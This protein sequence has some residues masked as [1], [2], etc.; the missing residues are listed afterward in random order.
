MTM[1]VE[2]TLCASTERFPDRAQTEADQHDRHDEL[3]RD[4]QPSRHFDAEQHQGE[5]GS[6][7]CECVAQSP[8]GAEE[9]SAIGIP[10][11]V[12]KCGNRGDVIRFEGVTQADERTD[13]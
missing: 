6:N 9:R 8:P 13:P 10:L 7:Q 12:E 3:E 5:T 4:G 2:W 1:E 11:T